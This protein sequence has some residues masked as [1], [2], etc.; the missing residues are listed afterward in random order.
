M[1]PKEK[2]QRLE[3]LDQAEK[4]G[5]Q[6]QEE[7]LVLDF[8][9]ARQEY[10]RE[11]Q[12]I[13]V[14]MNGKT[15]Q[16]PPEIPFPLFTFYQRHCLKKVNGKVMF[17]V[18]DDRIMEFLEL[19]FGKD[20]LQE[21]EDSNMTIPFVMTRVVPGIMEKWGFGGKEVQKKIEEKM[22]KTRG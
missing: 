8:D 18:P 16:L 10:E 7:S 2:Q 17:E 4:E 12:S 21:I 15:F 19:M 6:E 13:A 5:K 9:E 14:K 22:A 11:H 20:I 1:D 3:A